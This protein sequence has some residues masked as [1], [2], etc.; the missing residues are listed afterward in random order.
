MSSA[1]PPVVG[2]P[3]RAR[4]NRMELQFLP[5]ALEVMDTPA[6]PGARYTAA[7]LIGFFAMA[8]GWSVIGRVDIIAT[9]PGT[10]IPAGKTKIVQPLEAGVVKT[11]LV[12]DGDHVRA[13]QTLIELDVVTAAAERDRIGRDL[14]QA[15]LDAAGLRAL[16]EDLAAGAGLDSFSPPV[17]VPPQEVRNERAV[18]A[19]RRDEQLGKLASLVQQ[20]ASK[21]SAAAENVAATAK[22]AASLPILQQKRDLYRALLNVQFSNKLA[23]L[24][25]EQAYSDQAHELVVQRQHAV[26]IAADKAALMRQLEQTRAAYAHDV[27][28]DL[29][30]A[31]EKQGELEQQYAGAAHKAEQTVLTAPIDGTVQALSVHTVGGVVTPAEQ[32]LQVVP[33]GGPLLIEAM[34]GNRDV[35]FVHAGQA[36]AVKVATFQFTQYGLMHG[37]V[38]NVSRDATVDD[39][40]KKPDRDGKDG[41][42]VQDGDAPENDP[43]H[44]VAHVALDQTS[45]MVDGQEQTLGPGMAVTAEIKTG[46]R[47]VIS[48]LLSPLIKH[49]NEA[50]RER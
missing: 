40:R 9:A 21:Q 14:R 45:L 46:D 19:A 37:H 30:E 42:E 29:G 48:Y 7:T 39:A 12:Q 27:L 20:I 34:V 43:S 50:G 36:V 8:V 24:D 15:R 16:R 38:V 13:G 49:A 18:I 23:W 44:Y 6:S 28:K 31:E 5:A 25:S 22:L 1:N 11:I 33:D 26:E 47:T 3:I 41:Q 32:L 2:P 4:Q 17:D 10:V 35:G